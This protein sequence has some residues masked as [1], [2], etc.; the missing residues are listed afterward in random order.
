M[1]SSTATLPPQIIAQWKN[2]TGHRVLENFISTEA[3]T[4]LCN[5][6]AGSGVK[7]GPG[8][9]DCG[10]PTSKTQTQIVR[11]RDHTKSAYDVLATGD[12]TGTRLEGQNAEEENVIGELRLRGDSVAK[13]YWIDGKEE[14]IKVDDGWFD[15]GDIV[16]Y[17]KGCYK[18]WG[19]LN[20]TNINHKGK[21][22]NAAKIE[23]KV[24][25]HKDID[26]CYVVGIG[27]IQSEQKIAAM[28]VINPT[29][30]VNI[31]N[32]LEWCNENM[33][34]S[35]VPTLFKLVTGI[36]RDSSGHVDK[37]KIRVCSMMIRFCAFMTP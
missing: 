10:A 36:A 4:A 28:I 3:G 11:F 37:L 5:R 14:Q 8:C 7:P 35:E 1:M 26:D 32:I 29:K 21:M 27:D 34:E 22:V 17:H 33:E 24:L 20:M 15:T 13:N 18:V 16:Q 9:Q 25:S 23:K 2:V 30:K 19:R 31:E 12:E 6:V